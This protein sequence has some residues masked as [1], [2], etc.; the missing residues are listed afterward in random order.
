MLKK[1]NVERAERRMLEDEQAKEE[2]EKAKAAKEAFAN[3]KWFP[4]QKDIKWI[5]V[6]N[7]KIINNF[8]K[9]E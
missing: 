9:K 7:G 5:Q 6:E 2:A 3:Q 8:S 1:L 4:G